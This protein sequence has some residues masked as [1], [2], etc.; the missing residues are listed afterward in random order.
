MLRKANSLIIKLFIIGWALTQWLSIEH[1]YSNEHIQDTF[2]EWCSSAGSTSDDLITDTSVHFFAAAQFS[3]YIESVASLYVIASPF[4]I[5]Q[6]RAPP[7]Y[8]S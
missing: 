7:T 8:T 3:T 1:V 2:C 4:S 5:P 6:E